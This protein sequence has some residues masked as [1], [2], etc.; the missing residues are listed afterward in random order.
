MWAIA[1]VVFVLLLACTPAARA[2]HSHVSAHWPLDVGSNGTTPDSSGHDLAGQDLAGSFAP[3]RFSNALTVANLGDGFRAPGTALLEP[4]RIT[5]SAWVKASGPLPQDRQIVSKG[6]GGCAVQS[7]GLA[8]SASGGLWWNVL[9]KA[10]GGEQL[11]ALTPADA[12]APEAL[13]DDRW[14]AIA[15]TFDGA[16]ADLWVD[17]AKVASAPTPEAGATVDY[18]FPERR[19]AVGRYAQEIDAVVG[20]C[21]PGGFQFTGAIDEVRV[22]NRALSAEE[23]AQLHA[24]DVTTSPA[25]PEA[26]PGPLARPRPPRPRPPHRPAAG[27]LHARRRKRLVAR[28]HALL[29]SS[30][31]VRRVCS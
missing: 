19:L 31:S 29:T 22:Y 8:T 13:W 2:D 4:E 15:G 10:P 24:A 6:G 17:G 5:V 20:R 1:I 30:A 26:P 14:H 11:Q 25:L 9:L 27:R 18:S 7:Y 23:I 3:G 21:D 12:V 28:A 16:S